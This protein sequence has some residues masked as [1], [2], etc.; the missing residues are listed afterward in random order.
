MKVISITISPTGKPT[1]EA[2]GFQDASCKDAT[3]P[4]LAKLSDGTGKDVT[5]D[6]PEA[7]ITACGGF[8]TAGV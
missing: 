6:K 5:S 7:H 2:N 4:Y 8:V 3:K 1:I